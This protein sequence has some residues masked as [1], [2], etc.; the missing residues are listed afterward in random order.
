MTQPAS[1][2]HRTRSADSCHRSHRYGGCHRVSTRRQYSLSSSKKRSQ[3]ALSGRRILAIGNNGRRC[4]SADHNTTLLPLSWHVF[5][6]SDNSNEQQRSRGSQID[7]RSNS[8]TDFPSIEQ[9][10]TDKK[11]VFCHPTRFG[12][13]FFAQL[14]L[15]PVALRRRW[16]GRDHVNVA[17][18]PSVSGGMKAMPMS[19]SSHN[20][21]KGDSLK[22][23]AAA[24]LRAVRHNALL[25]VAILPMYK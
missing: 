1:L 21:F 19:L 8:N 17:T 16:C 14:W 25:P 23:D 7:N 15:Q 22:D 10:H 12:L 6:Y 11:S 24:S 18:W 4:L 20:R 3:A 13:F 2:L 5:F 9:L